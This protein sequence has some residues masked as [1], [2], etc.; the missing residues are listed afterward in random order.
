MRHHV[1]KLCSWQGTRFILVGVAQLVIDSTL[2]IVL[3][4]AGMSPAFANPISRCTVVIAGFWMHGR[5][6]F[7]ESG[8]PKLGPGYMARFF[9][10]WIG[11]TIIG[12][13]VLAGIKI[14]AGLHATWIAKP[15]VD[16]LLAV[17][18]FFTLRRWVFR[19]SR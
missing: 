10:A 7:A 8:V 12:T 3:T 18:S 9:P 2:F 16:A 11:L 13:L 5:Y 6:T 19:A 4:A 1:R 14:H 17:I 15:F